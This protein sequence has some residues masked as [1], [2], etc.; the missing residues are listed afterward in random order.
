MIAGLLAAGGWG[1][2]SDARAN[3]PDRASKFLLTVFDEITRPQRIDLAG[4][5]ARDAALPDIVEF[6]LDP[7][8][9]GFTEPQREAATAALPGW[10]AAKYADRIGDLSNTEITIQDVR[11]SRIT[12]VKI[13]T[14]FVWPDG[15]EIE[16][17]WHI[18]TRDGDPKLLDLILAG[19]SMLKRERLLMLDL[20][21]SLDGDKDALIA[22]LETIG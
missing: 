1:L 18:V 9:R 3:D 12:G 16:M 7:E 14:L 13:T 22:Q 5:I 19:D 6:I 15:R 11:R 2:P 20:L 10:L 17:D 4:L 8:L 21:E